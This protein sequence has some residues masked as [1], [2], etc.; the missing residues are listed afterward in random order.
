MWP[1]T[2]L[3]TVNFNNGLRKNFVLMS[4]LDKESIEFGENR[5]VQKLAYISKKQRF[6]IEK[7][8]NQF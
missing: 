4:I 6:E 1:K 5:F 7:C 3:V 8:R 2:E